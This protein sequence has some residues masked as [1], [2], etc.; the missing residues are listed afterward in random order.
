MEKRS[1]DR[2]ADVQLFKTM[3]HFWTSCKEE[4]APAPEYPHSHLSSHLG[5]PGLPNA[6]GLP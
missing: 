2:L 5:Y 6:A 1:M 4:P 3:K